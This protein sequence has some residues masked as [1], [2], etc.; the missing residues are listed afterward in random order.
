MGL[1]LE[2]QADHGIELLSNVHPEGKPSGGKAVLALLIGLCNYCD[3]IKYSNDDK[4][5]V[6]I[7]FW[8]KKLD[9]LTGGIIKEE[10]RPLLDC[11]WG[12]G[13]DPTEY[14][15]DEYELYKSRG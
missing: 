13:G 3:D 4:M 9:Q 7:F 8:Y 6:N 12:D 14:Q 15:E 1:R 10:C 2:I 5:M 11:M